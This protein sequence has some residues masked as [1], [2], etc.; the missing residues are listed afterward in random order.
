VIA[1]VVRG[2]QFDFDDAFIVF[3]GLGDHRPGVG[4]D[5]AR[6]DR[7]PQTDGELLDHGFGPGPVGQEAAAIGSVGKD[8]HEDVGRA[9][10]IG[11]VPVVV[12]RHEVPSGDGSRHDDR[13]G[14]VDD[15][16]GK[17]VTDL[18]VAPVEGFGER[19]HEEAFSGLNFRMRNRCRPTTAPVS[20]T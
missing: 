5:R 14:H 3:A 10:G 6:E 7:N 19:G 8:V 15:E 13:G 17:G 4:E 11:V 2:S 12:H 20:S 9:L 18:H 16:G 1:E